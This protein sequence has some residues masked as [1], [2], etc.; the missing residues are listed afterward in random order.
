MISMQKTKN[1]IG[2]AVP[3]RNIQINSFAKC[4]SSLKRTI[5]FFFFVFLHRMQISI[6]VHPIVTKKNQNKKELRRGYAIRLNETRVLTRLSAETLRMA[7]ARRDR[8][9]PTDGGAAEL[10]SE[11]VRVNNTQLLLPPLVP[12]EGFYSCCIERKDRTCYRRE[13]QFET[14]NDA[15]ASKMIRSFVPLSSQ[16]PDWPHNALHQHFT[17]K[18]LE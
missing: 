5:A 4:L 18:K 7:S 14:L 12:G 9:R 10:K 2:S 1:K 17:H 6:G 8:V 11:R 13:R 16:L 3:K 15:C